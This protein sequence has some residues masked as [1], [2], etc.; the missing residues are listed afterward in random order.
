MKLP[1]YQAEKECTCP[2]GR[3]TPD[4]RTDMVQVQ[5]HNEQI[6]AQLTY[7]ASSFIYSVDEV[8]LLY[9]D[10]LDKLNKGEI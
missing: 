9:K 10:Y 2:C 7:A 4:N 8:E 1:S 6:A 5:M 3:I